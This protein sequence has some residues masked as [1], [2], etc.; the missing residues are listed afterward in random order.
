MLRSD[1]IRELISA[2]SEFHASEIEKIVDLFF[3]AITAQLAQ[4]GRVELRGFGVFSA[5][6][7]RA[8]TGRNPKS[9]AP[10]EVP[11]KRKVHFKPGRSMLALLNKG[12]TFGKR[13]GSPGSV[14]REASRIV[15]G[16]GSKAAQIS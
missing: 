14:A 1:L 15:R 6:A 13:E 11:P 8:R 2:H 5:R 3:D 12:S 7:C 10:V 16:E 9:R 4:G